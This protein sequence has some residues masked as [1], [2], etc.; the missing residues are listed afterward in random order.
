MAGRGHGA[1]SRFLESDEADALLDQDL[2]W[3]VPRRSLPDGRPRGGP[4]KSAGPRR[5][6]ARRWERLLRMLRRGAG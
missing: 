3:R 5:R 4:N 6:A 1:R 2:G